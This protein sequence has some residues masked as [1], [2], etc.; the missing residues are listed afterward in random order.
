[1]AD[2]AVEVF[3]PWGVGIGGY[4]REAPVPCWGLIDQRLR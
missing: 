3:S 2:G 4:T 1:V